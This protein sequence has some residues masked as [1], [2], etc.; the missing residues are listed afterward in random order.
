ME[1]KGDWKKVS[2]TNVISYPVAEIVNKTG[3]ELVVTYDWAN[4]H[5]TRI[6]IERGE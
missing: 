1:R 6:V 4:G 2:Q 3:I 5:I